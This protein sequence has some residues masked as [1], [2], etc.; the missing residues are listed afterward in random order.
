ME[1]PYSEMFETKL[2]NPFL[3]TL[4]Q[5]RT[6]DE[7]K[8]RIR[9]ICSYF[10]EKRGKCFEFCYLNEE[11]AKEYFLQYL[12]SLC[13][14]SKLSYDS[15]CAELSSAKQFG[16]FLTE[17]IAYLSKTEDFPLKVYV[18]P[19]E[20]ILRPSVD[21]SIRTNDFLSDKELDDVLVAA[22]ETDIRIYMVFLLSLRMVLTEKTIL[23]LKKS[24]VNIFT[25]NGSLVGILSYAHNREEIH[26]RI[27]DDILPLFK[28]FISDK[29]DY[30]FLNNA[31]NK[32]SPMNLSVLINK[33]EDKL[34][35]RVTAK[36]L[37]TKALVDLC[38]Q[39]PDSE[40]ELSEYAGLSVR[41]ISGYSAA[42]DKLNSSYKIAQ[43]A[44]Y[45]IL[46]VR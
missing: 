41:S 32:L 6:K 34:G 13:E 29:E 30:L 18:N 36:Q 4:R 39:N 43:S 35:Y 38:K 16:R 40:K 37:R 5:K 23:S 2:L 45:R 8:R 31:G 3:D 26:K 9:K 10:Y 21:V 46:E 17:R 15:L 42:L 11:D 1:C 20:K 44:S 12:P 22:R 14:S 28:E 33:M 19:F 24:M 7:Y 25:E 27:P